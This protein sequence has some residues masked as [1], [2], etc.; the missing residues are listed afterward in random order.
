MGRV[1][2][3]AVVAVQEVAVGVAAVAAAVVGQDALDRCAAVVV[4]VDEVGGEG[5][6]VGC[7]LGSAQL[8]VRQAGVVVD[9]DVGVAP[10]GVAAG[11]DASGG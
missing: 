1:D 9:G 3:A 4:G 10:A 8:D 7:A 5:Q 2:V 6:A 11:L